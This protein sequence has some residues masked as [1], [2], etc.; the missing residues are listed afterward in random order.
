MFQTNRTEVKVTIIGDCG[1]VHTS[2][3]DWKDCEFCE[4]IGKATRANY[5]RPN[6]RDWPA[7]FGEGEAS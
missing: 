4:T 6:L 7:N 5:Y 3:S 1:G 2:L